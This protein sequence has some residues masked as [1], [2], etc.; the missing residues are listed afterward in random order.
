MPAVEGGGCATEAPVAGS[1]AAFA[2]FANFANFADFYRSSRPKLVRGLSLT[3]GDADLAA[4]A[5]DE[6]MA[7]A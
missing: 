4:E 7:R 5:V 6:A 3:L 2:N 1:P